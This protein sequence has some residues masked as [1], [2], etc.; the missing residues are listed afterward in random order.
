MAH[1]LITTGL[2]LGC[3]NCF[4]PKETSCRGSQPRAEGMRGKQHLL[5]WDQVPNLFYLLVETTYPGPVGLLEKAA[6]GN[7]VWPVLCSS[8]RDCMAWIP[9]RNTFSWRMQARNFIVPGPQG[10][11]KES[12]TPL[13]GDSTFWEVSGSPYRVLRSHTLLVHLS[14]I[15]LKLPQGEFWLQLVKEH[16][17]ENLMTAPAKN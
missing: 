16:C 12:K 17:E 7:A 2:C 6:R 11:S 5:T 8:T 3:S 1:S 13:E 9:L 15:P 4:C 14:Q 10:V